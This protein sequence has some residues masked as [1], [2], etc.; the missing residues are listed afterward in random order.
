MPA[1]TLGLGFQYHQ[2]DAPY[3][4]RWV[5]LTSDEGV[6][7]AYASRYL[8]GF[9]RRPP[10]AVYEVRALDEPRTDPDYSEFSTVYQRCRHAE[11]VRVVATDVQLTD[12]E[13]NRLEQAYSLWTDG[14]RVWD[15]DGLLKPSPEMLNNG[16]PHEWTA[17]LRPWLGLDYFNRHGQLGAVGDAVKSGD[18]RGV[19]EVVSALDAH[20]QIEPDTA[21]PGGYR[22]LVCDAT[23]PE[24]RAAVRHQLGDRPVELLTALH[25][26]SRE[27]LRELATAARERTPDRWSWLPTVA[28][29]TA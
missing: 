18:W 19:L 15:S 23:Q 3:D 1:T 8:D 22:C 11:I 17:M 6:A 4:P 12:A 5:Y 2:P 13:Q 26:A 28:H 21:V 29:R 9:G 14:T 20:C 25:G 27:P 10:G 7:R 16:V 24:L